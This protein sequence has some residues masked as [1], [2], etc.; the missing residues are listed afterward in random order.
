MTK[1]R[2]AGSFAAAA[3]L[4]FV[5]A[6]PAP[7]A[8]PDK[9][10]RVLVGQPAGGPT[11]A[12]ARII[13]DRIADAL[14]QPAVVENRPGAN[15]TIAAQALMASAPDGHTLYV[16]TNGTL[17]VYPALKRGLPY[18]TL[19]SFTPVALLS[20]YPYFLLLDKKLP[21]KDFKE[22]VAY[23]KA[24]PG[25]LSMS[26]S[27]IGSV[28]HLGGE[29]MALQ[30]GIKVTHV[31]YAGDAPAMTDLIAGNVAFGFGT[32]SLGAPQVK[33]G[34]VTA[35]AISSKQ[36]MPA[37]PDLPTVAEL[38]V[39]D[40]ELVPWNGMLAPAGTP[41]DRVQILNDAINA[42]LR[43]PDTQKRLA[44][45]GLQALVVT[46]DGFRKHLESELVRWQEMATKVGVTLD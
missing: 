20:S 12:I 6:A 2:F 8:F 31:P 16:G 3:C 39:P 22:F 33:A 30:L 29:Y 11:D 43:H 44:E 7:A 42:G 41:A 1:L 34:T 15:G 19:K 10:I 26:S 23:G 18:D 46:P 5:M 35:I 38:G 17:T 25:K 27:G 4:L 28:N 36:R 13:A 24:N 32:Y 21:I 45:L 14:K 40:Y 9:T 37:F